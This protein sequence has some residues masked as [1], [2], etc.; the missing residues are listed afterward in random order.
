MNIDPAAIMR[1]HGDPN[2][3]YRCQECREPWPCLPYRLAEALAASEAKVKRALA[4]DWTHLG[5]EEYGAGME[6]ARDEFRTALLGT[7]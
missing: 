1:E 6:H 3:D 2:R 4:I 7:A 5:D